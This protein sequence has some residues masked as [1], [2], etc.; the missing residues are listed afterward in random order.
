MCKMF[1]GL[2][3]ALRK[4]DVC[5]CFLIAVLLL[6]SLLMLG[7][8]IE[9]F[10]EFFA[11]A[12]RLKA[13]NAGGWF[14]EYQTIFAGLIAGGITALSIWMTLQYY[15]NEQKRHE[16][17]KL[18]KAR[19]YKVKM[20]D[21]LSEINEYCCNVF[22]SIHNKKTEAPSLPKEAIGIFQDSVMYVD[23][24]SSEVIAKFCSF[25][26]IHNSRLRN[27]LDKEGRIGNVTSAKL[28]EMKAAE[29]VYDCVLLNALCNKLY[30]YGRGE[31]SQVESS[32]ITRK[33]MYSS[34][35]F[36]TKNKVWFEDDCEGNEYSYL[37]WLFERI[38]RKHEGD[39][40]E[41]VYVPIL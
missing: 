29:T 41:P 36:V 9:P 40:P 30:E 18:A 4:C 19:G 13:D 3:A 25:Y 24:N 23:D 2:W 8:G 35:R 34:L 5:S 17:E 28:D 22:N 33:E 1:R 11:G 37:R 10:K 6:F 26:Q 16:A 21:A 7:F 38:E 32:Q 12:L 15:K 20:P 31:V 27:Y 39:I 14:Y